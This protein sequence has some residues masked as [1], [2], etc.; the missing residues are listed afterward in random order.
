MAEPLF[1]MGV[2]AILW[3]S[4]ALLARDLRAYHHA[5]LRIRRCPQ[6]L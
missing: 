5:E 2:L 1:L 4:G 3:L 6:R